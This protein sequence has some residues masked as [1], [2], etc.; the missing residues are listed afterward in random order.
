MDK[1][2]EI[3]GMVQDT[4]SA[5]GVELWGVEYAPRAHSS[6]VR[7]YIDHAD[8]EV[9]V[10]DCEAVS[11]E[12]SA[13]FDLNDPVRGQ[14]TLEV[15]SPG[16]DRPFFQAGQMTGFLGERVEASLH[17]PIEG[18]RR[19]QGEIA[20]VEGERV[21]LDLGDGQVFSFDFAQAAKIRIKPDYTKLL[22]QSG[23]GRAGAQ[24]PGDK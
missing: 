16:L 6:L 17:A 18:R 9:T 1:A 10:D 22:A 13:L 7:L 24:A 4:V 23:S 3:A 2:Q 11:R 21:V 20:A 8:R 14:F 12:V 19:I 5:L 15:S